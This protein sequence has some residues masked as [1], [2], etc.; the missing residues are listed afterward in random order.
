ME[1]LD[2][3]V[4]NACCWARMA[5]AVQL[6]YFRSGHLDVHTKLNESDIVT[7]ADRASEA[8]LKQNI[9]ATY[10]SHDILSEESGEEA[11][12]GEW[13]WVI[14]P[15][16]G[17]TN[18]TAG[19]PFFAVAIGI[20]HHG[21]AVAGV[22][23]APYLNELFHAIEGQG[24][25]LN[26]EPIKV[27]DNNMISRAVVSTG[28]PVDKSINPDNNLDVVERVL[29]HVRGL[30]RLGAASID[31]CYTAA[32]YL[33]AYWEMNLHHWDVCGALVILQEAGGTH[34]FYRHD[35][36]ISV[37]AATPSLHSQ[38]LGFILPDTQS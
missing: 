28:F 18:Y 3:M 35:R 15:L 20:E 10:P 17:T 9:K 21:H 7:K 26:G 2:E 29:P 34:T 4:M 19:L 13:R 36:N 27:R 23:F 12:D 8:L 38:M 6:E 22:V 11:N 25:W 33:D 1:L 37:L 31:I 30:R 24:A 32:G 5:G 14:D 16:D